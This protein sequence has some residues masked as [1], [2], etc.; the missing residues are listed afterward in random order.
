MSETLTHEI[1]ALACDR[2]WQRALDRVVEFFAAD[3]GTIHLIGADGALHL[4][5]ASRGIPQV[6]LDTV[7]VVPVGK[8][9][10]GLSVLRREPVSACNIQTDATGDV[11]PGARATG[12]Q[13]SIVVPIFRDEAAVGA[14][15]IGN[16][17]ERTFTDAETTLLVRVGR[18]I[19][20]SLVAGGASA[21][22]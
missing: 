17:G 3:S 10:A 14:L 1:H 20:A 11:R 21:E 6:V 22:P 5:A 15:G 18:A 7:T 12:L 4:T 2:A 8:G 9:M 13:G 19:G 16:R